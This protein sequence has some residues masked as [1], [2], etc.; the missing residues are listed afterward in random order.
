[1]TFSLERNPVTLPSGVVHILGGIGN[2][3]VNLNVGDIVGL[4]GDHRLKLTPDL[5]TRIKMHL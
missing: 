1:M 2:L 3:G 4:L 5:I